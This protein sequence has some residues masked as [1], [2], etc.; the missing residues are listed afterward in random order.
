MSKRAPL[1]DDD[2]EVRELTAEDLARFR[3]AHEVLPPDV[4]ETL[5]IRRRGPQKSPTK[6]ATTIRLSAEVVE[7]FRGTGE[8]WQSRIDGVLLEYVA[9][10][11]KA[12]KRALR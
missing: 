3:P 12:I 4:Q 7:H 10:A 6:V 8:G 2:G 5:G 11:D 1:I 9:K